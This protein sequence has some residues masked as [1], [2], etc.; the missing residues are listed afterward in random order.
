MSPHWGLSYFF[1]IILKL[2]IF[3]KE[4]TEVMGLSQCDIL[5]VYDAEMFY[6]QEYLP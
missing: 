1:I 4:I 5:R 6:H 3:V 2:S